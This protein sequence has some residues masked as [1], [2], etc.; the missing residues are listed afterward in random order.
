[1]NTQMDQKQQESEFTYRVEQKMGENKLIAITM[2]AFNYLKIK[3]T[4]S[5]LIMLAACIFLHV[6]FWKTHLLSYMHQLQFHWDL[7][8]LKHES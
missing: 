2:F 7:R 4:L 5:V 1:M 3:L 6:E 8:H